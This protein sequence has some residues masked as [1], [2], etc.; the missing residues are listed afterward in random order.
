MK[1]KD[2]KIPTLG[3]KTPRE[4]SKDLELRKELISLLNEIE[5]S[6]PTKWKSSK[7]GY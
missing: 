5:S 2:D 7:T 4:S 3:D 6:V 1:W